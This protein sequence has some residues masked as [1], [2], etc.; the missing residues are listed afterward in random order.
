MAQVA[1]LVI[2]ASSNNTQ[3]DIDDA[4]DA[5]AIDPT[6]FLD[7]IVAWPYKNVRVETSTRSKHQ[8]DISTGL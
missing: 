3:Q 5:A 6:D 2:T 1:A 7:P 4:L 8:R